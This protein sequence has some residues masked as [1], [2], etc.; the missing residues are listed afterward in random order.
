MRI[1]YTF[2]GS[3]KTFDRE[4][5]QV[6]IGRPK[7]GVEVDLDL[8]PDDTVSRP[9]ARLWMEDGHWWIEDLRSSHGTKVNQQDIRYSGKSLLQAGDVVEIG[10]TR[11]VVDVPAPPPKPETL[12]GIEIA[13]MHDAAA[14]QVAQLADAAAG[15]SKALARDAAGLNFVERLKVLCDLPLQVSNDRPLDEL[16]EVVLDRLVKVIP[17]AIRAAVLLCDAGSGELLPRAFRSPGGTGPAVSETLARRSI[18]E[19]KGLLW[20]RGSQGDLS[21]SILINRIESGMYAPLLWGE[22][23]FGVILVD[24]P[25]AGQ[26][27][28]DDDL[29]FLVAVAQYTAAAVANHKLAEDLRR[30]VL[31]Q[32]RLLTS[33]SPKLRQTLLDRAR[34]GRLRTGGE[35][36][37]SDHSLLRHARLYAHRGGHGSGRRG[38]HAQRISARP[39]RAYPAA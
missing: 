38:G 22:Q 37:G 19:R 17:G 13:A 30:T 25:Q 12:P 18:S 33:F 16:F 11:L 7:P 32:E 24:N 21:H 34:H 14:P 6:V 4:T 20:L 27:F 2:Q 26:P 39:H 23:T 1:H 9:H 35:R 29:R 28:L 10:V 3:T 5:T 31:I 15:V 36:F 8:S